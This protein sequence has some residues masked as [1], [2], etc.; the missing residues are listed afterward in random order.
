MVWSHPKMPTGIRVWRIA[1]PALRLSEPRC[2]ARAGALSGRCSSAA[3]LPHSLNNC[4]VA[5][6]GLGATITTHPQHPKVEICGLLWH[7]GRIAGSCRSRGEIAIHHFPPVSRPDFQ[8]LDAAPQSASTVTLGGPGS[9]R[10]G[11]QRHLISPGFADYQVRGLVRAG[12]TRLLGSRRLIAGFADGR[13]PR[14]A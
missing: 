10:R 11:G 14:R 5:F 7:R 9:D 12:K 1:L 4:L 13:W 6:L 2:T 8:G 3:P